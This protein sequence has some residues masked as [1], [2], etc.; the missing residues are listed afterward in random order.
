MPTNDERREAA[1]RLRDLTFDDCGD[2]ED[3]LHSLA[4]AIGLDPLEFYPRELARKLSDLID[5]GD[6]M[7]CGVYEIE[8]TGEG[9]PLPPVVDR[10][11]LL[12]LARALESEAESIFKQNDLK[13]FYKARSIKRTQAMYFFEIARRIREAVRE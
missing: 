3:R 12:A 6:E 10:D 1:R 8:G 13:F 9:Y 5:P 11:A 7:T 2:D 4:D